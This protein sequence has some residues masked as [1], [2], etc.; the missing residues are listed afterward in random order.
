MGGRGDVPSCHKVN[1]SRIVEIP[2]C[3]HSVRCI[4]RQGL[5]VSNLRHR[6]T[7][8]VVG[9][10][11]L[12][13]HGVGGRN[14]LNRFDEHNTR[15][16]VPFSVQFFP[17]GG[18]NGADRARSGGLISLYRGCASGFFASETNHRF[19]RGQPGCSFHFV[20]VCDR[21]SG[22]GEMRAVAVVNSTFL[23]VR[24]G[25]ANVAPSDASPLRRYI[26]PRPNGSR[27]PT[28][29]AGPPLS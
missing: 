22:G 18:R 26:A 14:P 29:D 16:Y 17:R 20:C 8:E 9:V 15:T 1:V 24:H 12:T 6:T 23:G 4:R 19:F 10:I 25:R 3:W 13:L 28:C 7:N 5:F 11:S 27:L 2:H 21:D